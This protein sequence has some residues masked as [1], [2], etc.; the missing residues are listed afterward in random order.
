MDILDIIFTEINRRF[1]KLIHNNL[2]IFKERNMSVRLI[3]PYIQGVTET[4]TKKLDYNYSLGYRCLNKLNRI[5]KI[6]KDSILHFDNNNTVYRLT[7]K[8]CDASYVDQSK[9]RLK[10]RIKEHCNNI[11]LA[12]DK[13]SV[14]SDHI[15]QCDHNFDWENVII[16]DQL[17][18]TAGFRNDLY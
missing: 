12:P 1:K 6:Q 3:M 4:I 2:F 15:I 13:H 7:C 17:S 9:R 11:K 8:N 5:V 10:T 18:Q 14:I 16:L